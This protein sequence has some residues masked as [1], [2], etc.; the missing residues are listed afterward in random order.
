MTKTKPY[1]PQRIAKDAYFVYCEHPDWPKCDSILNMG[2][3]NFFPCLQCYRQIES[4]VLKTL[5]EPYLQGATRDFA[6][7]NMKSPITKK[8]KR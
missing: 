5:L 3:Y 7:L 4:V 8:V 6:E 1:K 2:K